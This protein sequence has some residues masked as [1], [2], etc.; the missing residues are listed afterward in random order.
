MKRSHKAKKQN[1]NEQLL[2]IVNDAKANGAT[3]EQLQH[4]LGLFVRW[5]SGNGT[6]TK[7]DIAALLKAA[8]A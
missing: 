3:I 2:G 7:D 1:L 4:E 5:L 8:R 6:I